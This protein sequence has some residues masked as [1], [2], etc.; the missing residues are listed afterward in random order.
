VKVIPAMMTRPVRGSSSRLRSTVNLT[1]PVPVPLAP[2]V[3]VIQDTSLTA[4]RG[5]SGDDAVTVMRRSAPRPGTEL[6]VA[7]SENVQP[8][9]CV[10][11][12]VCPAMSS[13][14]VLDGPVVAA[15]PKDTLPLPVPP[16][17]GASVNHDARLLA[18]HSQPSLVVTPIGGVEGPPDA[19]TVRD[20]AL[21][22]Y[23]Q[24]F[25]WVTVNVCPAMSNVPVRAGPVC[26]SA[27]NDTL[28]L[29]VPPGAEVTVN[30]D[31]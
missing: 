1:S 3:T 16:E 15:T 17:L 12:N 27:L 9:D 20:V 24:P 10:T 13:V 7:L 19:G 18:V 5:Q 26:D 4:V 29:P 14:P 23:A 30:H 22:E 2:A 31:A 11:V 8:L 25:V 28:P 6:L 21:S